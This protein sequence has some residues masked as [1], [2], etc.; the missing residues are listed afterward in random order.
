MK[1]HPSP[2]LVLNPTNTLALA[3]R[4]N[5]E[6]FSAMDFH[7]LRHKPIKQNNQLLVPIHSLYTCLLEQK[8]L[9]KI[10]FHLDLER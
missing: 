7:E 1:Q 4:S 6:L 2:Q 5:I 9:H 8:T 10:L 3:P